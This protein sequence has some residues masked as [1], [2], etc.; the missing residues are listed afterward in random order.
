MTIIG[1]IA[2]SQESPE[3][4]REIALAAEDAGL[5]ELWLW[6]DSFYAGGIAMSTLALSVTER[7]RVG[8]GVMPIPYRNVAVA[9]MEVAAIVC[10]Y[11]G[12]FLP[13]FGHGVQDWMGQAGVRAPSFLT[14]AREYVPALRRLLA[15]D[16]VTVSGTYV[17]LDRVKLAFPPESAVPLYVAGVGPKS[18]LV[19]GELGDG[20]ILA[21]DAKVEDLPRVRRD[22]EAARAASGRDG[23]HEM[24][25]FADAAAD[26]A[27]SVIRTA[28]AWVDA[29]ADRVVFAPEPTDPDPVAFVR[30]IATQVQGRVG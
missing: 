10:L 1:A 5:D 30:F 2:R 26:D 8:I 22:I 28:R 11:P 14:L 15:G 27:D 24:V 16:E 21:G 18:L 6:E 3:K 25:V 12:R 7:L 17:N 9:A 19:S 4:I 13:G 23:T 29:G 20:T